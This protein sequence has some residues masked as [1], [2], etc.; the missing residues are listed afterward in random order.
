MSPVR[1]LL[2]L[3]VLLPTIACSAV[4]TPA[5]TTYPVTSELDFGQLA[6][7]KRGESCA[8]TI[9]YLFGPSGRAS[10][11]AAAQAGGLRRVRYVD[12]RYDNNVLRQRYCVVAYGE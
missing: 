8:K 4:L 7:M 6:G 12:N 9:L 5:A 3:A 10:V 1:R 11:A 2:I